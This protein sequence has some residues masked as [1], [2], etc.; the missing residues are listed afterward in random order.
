MNSGVELGNISEDRS[1]PV[2][3]GRA[4]VLSVGATGDCSAEE[5]DVLVQA[6]TVI[7]EAGSTCADSLIDSGTAV[8]LLPV[9]TGV[10]DAVRDDSCFV[11]AVNEESNPTAD[12]GLVDCNVVSFRTLTEEETDAEAV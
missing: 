10:I 4:V 5:T 7:A 9:T 6:N 11:P 12:L 3:P 8:T 1:F 2:N